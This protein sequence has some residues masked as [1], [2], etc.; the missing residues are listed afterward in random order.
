MAFNCPQPFFPFPISVPEVTPAAASVRTLKGP[1][2]A[3]LPSEGLPQEGG[4]D[5]Q[6]LGVA[7]DRAAVP[8]RRPP[9]L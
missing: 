3:A 2:S 1:P 9:G 6:L 7:M 5:G 4:E 8:A